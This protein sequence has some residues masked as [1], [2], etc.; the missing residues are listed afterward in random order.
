[1]S[2]T[3]C[4]P[5]RGPGPQRARRSPRRSRSP[6]A[7][8]GSMPGLQSGESPEAAARAARYAQFRAG[9]AHGEVLLTAHHAD[10]Q[11]ETILLQWLRGGGLRAVAGM[12]P[13]VRF[14][15]GWHA[16]PL[17][18]VSRDDLRDWAERQRLQWLEDPSNLDTRFDRNYLRLEVLPALRARWPAAAR[19][20]ARVAEYAAEAL[21]LERSLAATDLR[22]RVRRHHRLDGATRPACAGAAARRPARV[23]EGAGAA[24][25]VRSHARGAAA[26][27]GGRRGRPRSEG[28]AGR[29]SWCAAIEAGSTRSRRATSVLPKAP[30]ASPM[31]ASGCWARTARSNSSPLPGG[32]SV[33]IACRR[34]CRS[35]RGR[36]APNS[37]PPMRQHTAGRCASGFRS[38]ACCRGAATRCRCSVSTA[39]SS[40]LPTFRVR[41]EFAARPGEPSWCVRW[42]GRPA[43]TEQEVL[44]F[45]W[46][47]H[48][49]IH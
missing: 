17:L 37:A 30:G 12:R 5:S 4:T 19:T 41:A 42:R 10:D 16:R 14:G 49:P 15:P 35:S 23:A 18:G 21:E 33:A 34:T 1:M 11:L 45:N 24:V 25:A 43:L 6:A 26:R 3:A 8:S 2:I 39:G 46:P 22:G 29:A 7:V 32:G 48:P 44:A 47:E 36:M 20:A 28:R 13:C 38:T 27:H 9:L 31:R 40:Q